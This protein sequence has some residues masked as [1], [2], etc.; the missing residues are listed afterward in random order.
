MIAGEWWAILSTLLAVAAVVLAFRHF[1]QVRTPIPA[2]P[3]KEPDSV[4]SDNE[5]KNRKW[6]TAVSAVT[7]MTAVGA[8]IFTGLSFAAS[9]DQNAT[10]R[11]YKAVDQISTAGEANMQTRLGGIYALGRLSVDSHR[12]QPSI[13][14]VLSAFVR[15]NLPQRSPQS[16]GTVA[17]PAPA[18]PLPNGDLPRLRPDVEA[19]LT[20]L[21]RRD[22]EYDSRDNSGRPDLTDVCLNGVKLTEKDLMFGAL[23]FS[24]ADFTGSDLTQIDLKRADLRKAVLKGTKLRKCLLSNADMRGTDMRGADFTEAVLLGVEHDKLTQTDG[25]VEKD[26]QGAWW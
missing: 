25:A 17:C 16:N 13:N 1:N 6:Q 23:D 24:R 9:R 14:E 18:N 15:T 2:P 10:D 7:T 5:A 11:Y 21:G 26:A 4:P 22:P 8:V 12:D 19:A 3:T 20:V